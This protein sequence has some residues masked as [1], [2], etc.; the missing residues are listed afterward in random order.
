MD[1]AEIDAEV[2]AVAKAYFGVAED[3]RLRIM[4]RDGRQAL[5]AHSAAEPYDIIVVDA[6]VGLGSGVRAFATCEFFA[7]CRQKLAP[8]GV[9]VVNLLD[10][11]PYTPQK[12]VT[13]M[14]SFPRV[15]SVY[16]RERGNHVLFGC[17]NGQMTP[18]LLM[19]RARE[20]EGDLA[21]GFSLEGFAALAK[22]EQAPA[23]LF[24]SS[25]LLPLHDEAPNAASAKLGR[26]DVCFCGSGKKY[27][28][29]HG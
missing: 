20:W 24:A 19:Q 18:E 4:V 12:R 23:R 16:D 6:F 15:L 26:N 22:V 17:Q 5:A 13:V 11:D 21:L 10:N 29:C 14:E 7:L 2:V 25:P 1:C 9:V 3:A 8:D 27:K 28:K